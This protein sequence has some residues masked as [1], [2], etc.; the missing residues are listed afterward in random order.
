MSTD[1]S[2][3]TPCGGNCSGCKYF[4]EGNCEGC[5]TTK[6]ICIKMWEKGCEIYKCCEKHNTRFCGI[7]GE[8]PCE[9]LES[10]IGEWD[11]DG[12]VKLEKLADEYRSMF[13]TL[14]DQR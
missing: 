6:G 5:L 9:W 10:K 8:F 3:I 1:F 2:Q 12:I 14:Y 4:I 7:C 11:K 13:G